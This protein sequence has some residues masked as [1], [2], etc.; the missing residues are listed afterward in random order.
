MCWGWAPQRRHG[1]A[2]ANARRGRTHVTNL[3]GLKITAEQNVLGLQIPMS[4]LCQ[5]DER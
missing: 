3:G 5:P 4:H 1:D 2:E